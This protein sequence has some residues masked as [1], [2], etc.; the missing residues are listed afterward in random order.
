MARGDFD[1]LPGA[2]KPIRGL[3]GTHDPQWWVK[4]LIEREKITGVGP[5]ALLLRKEDAELDARL[6]RETTAEGV[7]RTVEDFN[8]RVV[9]ARRQ[10]LGGPPVITATRDPDTEVAAW[11]E[12]RAERRARQRQIREQAAQEAA[13]PAGRRRWW[14]YRNARRGAPAGR[15]RPAERPD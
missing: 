4:G 6:D 11:R 8:G 5:A 1:D 10:L 14:P 9:S 2:G 13:E 3:G 7:R 12:R 15:V